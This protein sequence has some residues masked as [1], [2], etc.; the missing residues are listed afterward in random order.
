MTDKPKL[1]ISARVALA[2]RIAKSLAVYTPEQRA[3]I[4][5]WANEL[6]AAHAEDLPDAPGGR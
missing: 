2:K 3:Q 4:L 6:L 5:E 1:D